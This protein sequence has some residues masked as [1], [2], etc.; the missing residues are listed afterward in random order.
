MMGASAKVT[1][2]FSNEEVKTKNI[3]IIKRKQQL[4]NMET[5]KGYN[6]TMRERRIASARAAHLTFCFPFRR[7]IQ[8]KTKRKSLHNFSKEGCRI[9]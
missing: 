3:I 5:P 1:A 4:G 6:A 2:E 8:H 7:V 9:F